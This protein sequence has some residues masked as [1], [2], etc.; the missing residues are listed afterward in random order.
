MTSRERR[1]MLGMDVRNNAV[2]ARFRHL[3]SQ[4]CV[5]DVHNVH[6]CIPG[7]RGDSKSAAWS[8][9]DTAGMPIDLQ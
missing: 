3:L 9:T 2:R 4:H 5:V 6:A 1:L 8:M 7:E